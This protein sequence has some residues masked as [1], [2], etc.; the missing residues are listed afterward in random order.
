[1]FL[2]DI[3]TFLI[4]RGLWCIFVTF[5][6]SMTIKSMFRLVLTRKGVWMV[7]FSI[8]FQVFFSIALQLANLVID[9][10]KYPICRNGRRYKKDS[11]NSC[12][13]SQ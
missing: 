5:L 11:G 1:M 12:T 13:R 4:F 3:F 8:R 6:S 10:E 9:C 2:L 7:A